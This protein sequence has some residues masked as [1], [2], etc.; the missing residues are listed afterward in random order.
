MREVVFSS[1]LAVLCTA[2][3]R[4]VSLCSRCQFCARGYPAS[5]SMSIPHGV[6]DDACVMG[7]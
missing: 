2:V 5:P 3:V 4:C 6:P 1:P 7:C